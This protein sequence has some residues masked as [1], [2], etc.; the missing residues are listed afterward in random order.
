MAEQSEFKLFQKQ[1]EQYTETDPE[2]RTLFNELQ[3]SL[4]E[5]FGVLTIYEAE[6]LWN[7]LDSIMSIQSETAPAEKSQG[8]HDRSAN[9]P[10]TTGYELIEILVI[11]FIYQVAKDIWAYG[12]A[13]MALSLA[14]KQVRIIKSL[15]AQGMEKETATALVIANMKVIAQRGESDEVFSKLVELSGKDNKDK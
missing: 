12:R 10:F 14:E 11:L 7:L 3:E 2:I 15:M 6:E 8:I 1:V 9:F 13:W 4:K 5:R